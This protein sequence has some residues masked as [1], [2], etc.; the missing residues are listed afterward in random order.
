MFRTFA[1]A[2][3]LTLGMTAAHADDASTD[4]E[5]VSTNVTYGDLDLSRPADVRI[6]AD[7]LQEAAMSVCL[8]ANPE[9]TSPSMLRNCV[10]LSVSMAMSRIEDSLDQTVHA[11]LVDVRTAM[12]AP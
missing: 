9:N 12:Q 1:A 8:K 3:I 5:E 6:L 2:A 4:L 7:R 11:K 10:N